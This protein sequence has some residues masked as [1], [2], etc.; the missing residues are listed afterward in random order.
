MTCTVTDRAAQ[1]ALGAVKDDSGLNTSQ[2]MSAAQLFSSLLQ[3]SNFK[4]GDVDFSKLSESGAFPFGKLDAASG[5][6]GESVS[7]RNRRSFVVTNNIFSYYFYSILCGFHFLMDQGAW[8]P[9][10]SWT[11]YNSRTRGRGRGI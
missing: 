4:L 8:L 3:S 11:G 10:P 6:F 5:K 9:E 7:G 2:F 1:D